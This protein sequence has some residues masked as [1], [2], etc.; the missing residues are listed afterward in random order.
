MTQKV[1]TLAWTGVGVFIG[2]AAVVLVSV[3]T[4]QEAAQRQPGQPV[5][6]PS[7]ASTVC[8]ESAPTACAPRAEVDA[9]LKARAK[10]QVFVPATGVPSPAPPSP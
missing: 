4:W 9:W 5:I 8:L 10:G 3:A 6:I 7:D 1:Q 2:L